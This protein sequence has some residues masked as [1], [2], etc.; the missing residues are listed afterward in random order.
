MIEAKPEEIFILIPG[1]TNRLG[2]RL[3]EGKFT[4]AYLEE[5]STLSMNPGDM[6]RLELRAGDCAY[7]APERSRRTIEL[8]CVR[9]SKARRASFG[10]S[11][12][13]SPMATGPAELMG[14]E[15]RYGT[16]M[17]DNL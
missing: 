2:A 10:T 5:T 15:T 12:V 11:G 3:N 16:G 17:P 6:A 4:A 1:R 14:S 13:P 8:A 7:A 9:A